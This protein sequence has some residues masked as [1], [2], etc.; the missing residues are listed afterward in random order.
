MAAVSGMSSQA[1][2]ITSQQ[3]RHDVQDNDS[4]DLISASQLDHEIPI[5][6]T[7]PDTGISIQAHKLWVGNLDKRLTQ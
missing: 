1:T 2:L 7:V 3:G 4:I 6:P 5:P